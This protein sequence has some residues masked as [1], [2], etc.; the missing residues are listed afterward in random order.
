MYFIYAIFQR[1]VWLISFIIVRLVSTFEVI[2]KENIED[3]KKPLLIISNHRSFLDPFIIGQV[4]PFF[5]KFIPMSFMV[6]DSYYRFPLLTPFFWLTQT[7]PT[8]YGMGLDVSLK[9]PRRVLKNKGVFLIFPTGTRHRFGPR[10]RP[11]RGA[12]VLALENTR[13]TILPIY[14]DMGATWKISDILFRKNKITAIIGQPFKLTEKTESRDVYEVAEFLADE[15]FK[16][17]K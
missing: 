16:L 13:L 15:I 8:H 17:G 4:F 9:G 11:R 14:L 5:S 7:F 2:G 3:S 1:L 6:K 10:P 12:A